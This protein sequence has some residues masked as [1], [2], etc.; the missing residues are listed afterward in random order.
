MVE[1][2]VR[3]RGLGVEGGH[4]A[5]VRLGRVGAA[6]EHVGDADGDGHSGLARL[7]FLLHLVPDLSGPVPGGAVPPVAAGAEQQRGAVPLGVQAGGV[8]VAHEQH[9]AA[10]LGVVAHG[11]AERVVDRVGG[12]GAPALVG[13]V[14]VE[15]APHARALV[16]ADGLDGLR[17]V[18]EGEV[19]VVDEGQAR[20]RVVGAQAVGEREN[21]SQG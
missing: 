17:A 19:R 5:D 9:G 15:A 2:V 1:P 12:E 21:V 14:R 8:A 10:V 11:P 16:A 3:P 4:L 20:H 6:V 7:E 13:A 18:V